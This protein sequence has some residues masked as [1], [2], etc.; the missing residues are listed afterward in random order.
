[1]NKVNDELLK[2]A[3]FEIGPVAISVNT[4]PAND[5]ESS[6][7][8]FMNYKS[9]VYKDSKCAIGA[10]H[11]VVAVGYGTEQGQDF[12]VIRNS[13]GESWGEK[14]YMRI[15]RNTNTCGVGLYALYPIV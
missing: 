8:S 7:E 11:A 10:N 14:G 6:L 9:G 2:R 4:G 12:F 15:S 13:W 3:I 5:P 1:M